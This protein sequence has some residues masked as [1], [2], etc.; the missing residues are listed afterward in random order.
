MQVFWK[1]GY[2]ATSL[3][4]ICAA[5][6]LNRPSLYAAFGGKGHISQGGR[7]F[8][9][10]GAK[11]SARSRTN[12][13]GRQRPPEGNHG[14]RH[15][16]VHRPNRSERCSLRMPGDFHP[17]VGSCPGQGHS[18]RFGDS[19]RKNGQRLCQPHPA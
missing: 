19:D 12:R 17:S 6:N 4:Q 9:R 15:R 10:S 5:T 16:P 11:P 18:I 3:D 8:R 7:T 13:E 14:R 2:A 1:H